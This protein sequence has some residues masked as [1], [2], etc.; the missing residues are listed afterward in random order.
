MHAHV[1]E[2]A[3][4]LCVM[5][6]IISRSIIVLDG[7]PTDNVLLYPIAFLRKVYQ[8]IRTCSALPPSLHSGCVGVVSPPSLDAMLLKYAALDARDK[9]YVIISHGEVDEAQA[10]MTALVLRGLD[11]A[12]DSGLVEAAGEELHSVT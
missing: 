11:D 5:Y 9:L 1:Q 7:D 3:I 2:S 8:A 12:M 10:V 4:S 6:V